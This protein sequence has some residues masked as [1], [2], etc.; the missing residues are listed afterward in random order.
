MRSIE[1]NKHIDGGL[2]GVIPDNKLFSA[3]TENEITNNMK[4]IIKLGK[5]PK[6][7]N[8]IENNL[9]IMGSY[10]AK[11]YSYFS[12]LDTLSKIH[13]NLD[14]KKASDLVSK[15]IIK[16]CRDLLKYKNVFY[17]DL[18]A[19]LLD[20]GTSAH[21]SLDEVLSGRKG[22]LLLTE[23]VSTKNALLKLDVVAPY[24][25]RYIEASF[26]YNI[27]YNDGYMTIQ[28][29]QITKEN[30]YNQIVADIQ[31]QVKNGN[32]FKAI[33]RVYSASRIVDDKKNV[34][35][36]EPLLTS[37]IAKLSAIASDLKTIILLIEI[38]A[39]IDTDFTCKMLQ[40]MKDKIS[41]IID[42]DFD[43]TYIDDS[44]D[45]LCDK[46]NIK[47]LNKLVDYINFI[48]NRETKE[49]LKYRRIKFPL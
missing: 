41:N 20:D 35:L 26:I 23:A 7:A 22:K 27:S 14:I 47:L 11:L 31:K 19:G 10:Y 21:W 17:T 15:M 9:I 45:S 30:F 25:S 29:E 44:I 42:I 39:N 37:N 4:H 48:T 12:D 40:M 24:Y 36:I 2:I 34:R 32:L 13:I 6:N 16:I 38:K 49:Y 33:K 5:F 46:L 18:K 1:R 3:K 8:I 43:E 28:P